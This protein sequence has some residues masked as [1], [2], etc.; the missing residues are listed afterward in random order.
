M[1][2]EE[3]E[4]DSEDKELDDSDDESKEELENIIEETPTFEFRKLA[5][6]EIM[7]ILSQRQSENLEQGLENVQIERKDNEE[8]PEVYELQRNG[9]SYQSSPDYFSSTSYDIPGRS[10]DD[11]PGM[12]RF[13][14]QNQ[15]GTR[16]SQ[17]RNQGFQ[18]KQYDM[19]FEKRLKEEKKKF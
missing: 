5:L 19:D 13:Q 1:E 7:P 15:F 3:S 10:P 17:E 6:E 9:T 8:K 11:G 16:E 18:Q 4:E 14:D 12:T 2:E